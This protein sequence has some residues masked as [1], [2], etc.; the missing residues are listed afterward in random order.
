VA[1][2]AKALIYALSA[3]LNLTTVEKN[4]IRIAQ[5]SLWQGLSGTGNIPYFIN[6]IR[7][8]A[9]CTSVPVRTRIIEAGPCSLSVRVYPYTLTALI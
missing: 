1:S 4:Q 8:L 6:S 7:L 2:H 5:R 9:E 3:V